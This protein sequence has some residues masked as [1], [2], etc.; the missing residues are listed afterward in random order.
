MSNLAIA[1]ALKYQE[2]LEETNTI[3][4]SVRVERGNHGRYCNYEK[5]LWPN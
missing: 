3:S 5:S 4:V 2:D 1:G